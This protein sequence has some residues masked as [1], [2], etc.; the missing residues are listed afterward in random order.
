MPCVLTAQDI[1]G[2]RGAMTLAI[3]IAAHALGLGENDRLQLTSYLI[4]DYDTCVAPSLLAKTGKPPKTTV[5]DLAAAGNITRTGIYPQLERLAASLED[6]ALAI[7]M[8]LHARG[9]YVDHAV[10]M[11][12]YVDSPVGR[13]ATGPCIIGS[14]TKRRQRCYGLALAGGDMALAAILGIPAN[15]MTGAELARG[16][17]QMLARADR[18]AQRLREYAAGGAGTAELE[19]F[20]L[21]P[22]TLATYDPPSALL[23]TALPIG[24]VEPAAGW[25]RPITPEPDALIAHAGAAAP[26]HTVLE[27]NVTATRT[28]WHTITARALQSMLAHATS[29]G[30]NVATRPALLRYDRSDDGRELQRIFYR[31]EPTTSAGM[32]DPSSSPSVVKGFRIIGFPDL[33]AGSLSRSDSL[34]H[35]RAIAYAEYIAGDDPYGKCL[36]RFGLDLAPAAIKATD[37]NPRAFLRALRI[38]ENALLVATVRS[39][40]AAELAA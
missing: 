22:A 30:L 15:A 34:L 3:Q 10:W 14:T 24:P 29:I 8:L 23:S 36:E 12:C 28:G 13:G 19:V 27:A 4:G 11:A 7:V 35:A 40:Q 31:S 18:V 32:G 6:C 39:R 33:T 16:L 26:V 9:D 1:S 21:K 2:A 38:A 5:S 25:R 20:G 37:P 17:A